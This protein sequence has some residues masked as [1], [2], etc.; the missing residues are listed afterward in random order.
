MKILITIL[1]ACVG[2]FLGVIIDNKFQIPKLNKRSSCQNCKKTLAWLCMIPILSFLFLKGKCKHCQ[3]QIPLR[4]LIIE[5]LAASLFFFVISWQLW[6]PVTIVFLLL[7]CLNLLM[8]VFDHQ[9]LC[10]KDSYLILNAG[11]CLV[12]SILSS[13]PLQTA[14][15][16]AICGFGIFYLL[17][18][19]SQKKGVGI[20]DAYILGAFG[21]VLGPGLVLVN[22]M[23]CYWIA[24][25]YLLLLLITRGRAHLPKALGLSPFLSLGF[26]LSFKYGTFFLDLILK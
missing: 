16:G 24:A 19:I 26:L 10:L 3:T 18:L 22:F 23:L 1:G 12:L 8:A 9:N 13:I 20:G 25:I 11:L 6:L 2:S 17:Y 14:F 21:L 5:I 7:V 4:L 15:Q